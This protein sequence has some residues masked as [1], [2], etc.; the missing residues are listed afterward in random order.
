MKKTAVF[1]FLVF[2]GIVCLAQPKITGHRGCRFDG[3]YENTLAALKFAQDL[4]IESVEFDIQLTSDKKILVYHGPLMPDDKTRNIHD[5][6]F[7]EA[8]AIVLPGG[9]QMPTLEEWFDQARKTPDMKL[10]MEIKRQEN[11]DLDKFITDESMKVVRDCGMTAQVDY[12]SFGENICDEVLRIDPSAKVLFISR[13]QKVPW[14]SRAIEK[15]YKGISYDLDAFLNNPGLAED[16]EK[17]G[18]ETTLWIVNNPEIYDWAGKHHITWTTSDHP[19]ILKEH[20]DAKTPRGKRGHVYTEASSLTLT[21][22]LFPDTP[23]PYHRVDVTRFHGFT[24]GENFQMR[25]A[26]GIAVAFRTDSP[27]ISVMTGYGQKTQ[28]ERTSHISA[29]GYDLY[30]REN[31]KWVY[32]GSGVIEGKRPQDAFNVLSGADGKMRDYLMYLPTYCEVI[33]VK[34]GVK[35]G[36]VLE[37]LE[38]PFRHRIGVFGSSYT[39]GSNTSRGGMTW[40]AQFARE[41]GLDVL[42]IGLGGNCRLQD[43]FAEVLAQADVEAIIVD[44]FSNPT[45]EQMR[46]R[47]FPFIERVQVAHPG[48]P[49]IFLQTIYRENRNFNTSS[50]SKEQTKID[51]ADSLM[52]IACKR[53][54]DVY[55][56]HPSAT[57][58]YYAATV[59]GVHPSDHGY[60]LWMESVKKPIL[61]ILKKYGI[62]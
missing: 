21:G 34:I 40:I 4:G 24:A 17:K 28:Q 56:L 5:M 7:D 30:A 61:R 48:K 36:S 45:P 23:N 38:Y 41:T 50:D 13:G 19:E 42:S 37:P 2:A 46:E 53:Y 62:K 47:L 22:K 3:P 32:A 20:I 18:I 55:F 14:A 51:V 12:T 25:S 43:Y 16:A 8:R 49:L 44:A 15:G 35:E 31:E 54:K 1:L 57:S 59:D 29:W 39:Q 52:N 60:W 27:E 58:P 33:S 26:S 11:T 9:H 10:I 6:T